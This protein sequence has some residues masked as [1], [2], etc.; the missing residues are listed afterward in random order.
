M[1][2]NKCAFVVPLHPK[3]FD[4][5]YYIFYYLLDKNV[6]LY[7]VFTYNTD[8]DDFLSKIKN[9]YSEKLKFLILSDFTCI[10]VV[11]KTNSFI[12]IK[13]LFALSVLKDKYDYISCI[14]SEIR[15]INDTNNYYNIMKNI[16]NTKIICGGKLHDYAGEKYIVQ[17]SLTRLTDPEY[18][19][20]LKS[21]SEDYRIYTWWC[22]LPVYDCK[23]A[24]QFLKWIHFNSSVESLQR[25]ISCVFDDMLYNFFCIL[26]DN[27]QFKHI[28][29]C[30]H[31]LEFSDSSMV[32]TVDQTICKLYWVNNN[33]FSQNKLYYEKNNFL[34]VFHLDRWEHI[35][36]TLEILTI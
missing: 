35:K 8:K 18:H 2:E 1:V 11:E 21:L 9:E 17:E 13:K 19:D 33:A 4:Y 7:F 29:N 23:H 16:V 27:Y 36:P 12:S 3:H 15:F 24:D 28:N 34:I 25:F 30:Y 32:E 31:S 10:E 22:N 6:D 20:I 26:F 14:D 5:G